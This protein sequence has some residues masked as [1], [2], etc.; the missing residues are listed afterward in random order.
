MEFIPTTEFSTIRINKY[1]DTTFLLLPKFVEIFI[2]MLFFILCCYALWHRKE[3]RE[4]S[5][6]SD[7]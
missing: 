5:V 4:R 6:L 3:M 2:S 1:K 7:R